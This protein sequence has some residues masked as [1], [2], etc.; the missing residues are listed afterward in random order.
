MMNRNIVLFGFMGCGKSTVGAELSAN[1]GRELVDTDRLIEQTEGMTVSR[2]FAERGEQYF[3]DA[4]HRICC[5]LAGRERLII[6]AGGGALTFPRNIEALRKG[7]ELV[8]IDVPPEVIY[9]RLQYDTTRP[10]LQCEDKM[11]AIRDL[12]ARRDSIYR[13]AAD[14]TVNGDQPRGFVALD[15]MKAVGIL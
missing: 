12:Y 3:R 8:L 11:A 5:E 13:Q 14:H 1:T 4:E 6:S 15:I 9:Q 7:C 2:I 10:L